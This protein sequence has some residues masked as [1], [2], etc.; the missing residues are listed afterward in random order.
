M[1]LP[2]AAPQANGR[3]IQSAQ[4]NLIL[5]MLAE[6]VAFDEGLRL[7]QASYIRHVIDAQNGHMGKAASENG[8]AS[9][10]SY[11]HV[12]TADDPGEGT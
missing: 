11:S 7:F 8:D 6:G 3:S 5:M 4:K 9:K 12:E 1:T 2:L 10:S